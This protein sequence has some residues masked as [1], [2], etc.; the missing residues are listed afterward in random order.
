[1]TQTNYTKKIL[2]IED[3]ELESNNEKDFEDD[4]IIE[5]INNK[6]HGKVILIVFLIL[7][8]ILALIGILLYNHII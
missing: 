3:D 6:K 1:M 8:I 7:I 2:N 4:Q 5:N